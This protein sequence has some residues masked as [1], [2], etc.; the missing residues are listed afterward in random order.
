[1]NWSEHEDY[2]IANYSRL[3][4]RAM[5]EQLGVNHWTSVQQ[6]IN[7]LIREGRLTRRDRH[8]HREWTAEEMDYLAE[9][10]GLLPD[11]TVARRLGRTV[12]ACKVRATRFLH[13]SRSQQ[14]LTAQA[15]ARLFGVDV[16]VVIRRW[17]RDGLLRARRSAVNCGGNGRM[18][19]I[20]DA[21]LERFVRRYPWHYD[22][23][24]IEWGTYWRNLANRVWARDP[25]LG[26]V[27]AA[28]QLGI[29]PNTLARWC[30]EG[31]IV[32]VKTACYGGGNHQR[33]MLAQ[34][35]V[36]AFVVPRTGSTGKRF[37]PWRELREA[38]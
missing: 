25:Y 14:F 6:Q 21:D 38:A 24:R 18:W 27:E 5:A 9:S 12:A 7:R 23:T 34:S 31:R 10:W 19:R 28:A 13:L 4:L 30:R 2:L 1:M 22:R 15:V 11:A 20:D 35:V 37:G 8:W 29:H 36:S 26:V 32:A 17:I 33:W 16:H 3:T